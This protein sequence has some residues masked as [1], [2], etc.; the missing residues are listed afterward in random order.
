MQILV[1]LL[2]RQRQFEWHRLVDVGVDLFGSCR[3][4]ACRIDA[5][6][7]QGGENGARALRAQPGQ[8]IGG[9]RLVLIQA[10]LQLV[11]EG[12]G[13][14]YL[15]LALDQQANALP[16]R[17]FLLG[18]LGIEVFTSWLAGEN[19]SA[20]LRRFFL[21]VALRGAEAFGIQVPQ[22]AAHGAGA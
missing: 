16:Y 15:R 3:E 4:R 18:G 20:S 13:I 7:L 6:F 19:G 9:K 12:A 17:Q 11:V 14:G 10:L 22:G 1:A 8:G 21:L 5:G 2:R